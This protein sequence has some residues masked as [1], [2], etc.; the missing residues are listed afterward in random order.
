MWGK[1][2]WMHD[3]PCGHE[4]AE[5]VFIGVHICIHLSHFSLVLHSLI[6]DKW[7]EPT[8]SYHLWTPATSLLPS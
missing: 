1:T 7:K 3:M 2:A 8:Q 6:Q 5:C 4:C